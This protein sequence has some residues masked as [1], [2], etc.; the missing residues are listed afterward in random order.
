MATVRGRD[1]TAL[2][3]LQ[4]TAGGRLEIEHV[5]SNAPEQ[6]QALRNR[7]APP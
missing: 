7:L 2:H 5:D 4:E 1:R 6:V 3:E